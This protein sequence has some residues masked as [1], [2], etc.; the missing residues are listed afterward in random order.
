MEVPESF[1]L[2]FLAFAFVLVSSGTEGGNVP[3]AGCECLGLFEGQESVAGKEMMRMRGGEIQGG[4]LLCDAMR[5]LLGQEKGK[6]I[7]SG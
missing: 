4:G 2:L 3:E 1:P 5:G 6:E 7:A